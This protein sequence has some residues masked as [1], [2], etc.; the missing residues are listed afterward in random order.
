MTRAL[1][2][3]GLAVALIVAP[4][5]CC[6]KARGLASV[7]HA[8]PQPAQPPQG[9]QPAH[10]CCE[11]VVHSC[12]HD[13]QPPATPEKP[14]P[15]PQPTSGKCA[16]GVERPTAAQTE[17]KLTVAAAEPTGELLPLPHFI[18]AVTEHRGAT[19]GTRPPD[20]GVDAKS[21]ALFDRHVMRC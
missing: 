16:C 7:A 17:T 13:E 5:L 2:H 3:I 12:C 10:S 11:K 19:R 21:A 14:E 9:A 20:A 8:H 6:C 15:A 4:A 1:V 18:A